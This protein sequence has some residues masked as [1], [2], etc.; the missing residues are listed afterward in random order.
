MKTQNRIRTSVGI[1]ASLILATA[2][3]AG[4]G[5]QY[6]NKLSSNPAEKTSPVKMDDH[7]TGKCDGCKTNRVWSINDRGIA[8]KGFPPGARVSGSSHSCSGC[9]GKNT[10]EKGKIKA[11]M[12][13][14]DGCAKLVCCK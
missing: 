4:P 11:E 9:D 7:P 8:G 13:H 1:L 6:W 3:L 5:P 12:K 14:S 10:S 2:A